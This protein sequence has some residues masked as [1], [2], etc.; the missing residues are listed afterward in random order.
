MLTKG[1]EYTATEAYGPLRVGDRI[2]ITKVAQTPNGMEYNFI[3]LRD[4]TTH[5]GYHLNP[6]MF[7]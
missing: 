5:R 1:S 7:I 2:R 6:G 3:R 4:N